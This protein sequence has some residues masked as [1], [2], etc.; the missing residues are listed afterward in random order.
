MSAVRKKILIATTTESPP[1]KTM[2]EKALDKLTDMGHSADIDYIE[3][4]GDSKGKWFANLFGKEPPR[5][6]PP[7]YVPG[8]YDEV[9]AVFPVSGG[10]IPATMK[11]YLDMY[12]PSIRSLALLSWGEAGKMDS[13]LPDLDEWYSLLP[14]SYMPLAD[15]DEQRA[16]RKLDLFLSYFAPE[17]NAVEGGPDGINPAKE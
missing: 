11:A 2:A 7:Q 8:E 13:V 16:Q 14:R 5:L 10:H 15:E 3:I 9:I 12:L 6:T 17:S 1:A 4:K